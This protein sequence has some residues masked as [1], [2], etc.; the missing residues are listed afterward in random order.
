[1]ISFII[2][3]KNEG[4][5]LTRCIS[6]VFSF[7][8]KE[9]INESEVIYVDSKSTDDSISRAKALNV[10]KILSIT[11]QCNAAI[12]RNI[13]AKE[14]SG[15]ILFFLDGDME[16]IPGF[17]SQIVDKEG[18]LVYPFL[19]GI[20]RDIIHTD[21]GEK[22][23]RIRR[24]YQEGVDQYEYIT[25]GLFIIAADLWRKVGGMDTRLRI[26][27]DF[28]LGLRLSKMGFRLCRKPIIFVNHYTRPY[29]TRKGH[30]LNIRF[31]AFLLRKHFFY[32]QAHKNTFTINY[33][34]VML[35]LSLILLALF[36]SVW[37][38]VPYLIS[39]LYKTYRRH[40][41][42]YSNLN[43]LS[44]FYYQLKLDILFICFFFTFF[45]KH[46]ELQYSL[47]HKNSL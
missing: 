42:S 28:D 2:I 37:A 9:Q 29:E 1:M 14:S 41:T 20:E 7:I 47:Y 36:K 17:Y 31:S 12:A 19:S 22:Q 43:Y 30:D 34:C 33:P 16:L 3:G 24:K 25:G 11:G 8:K 10:N 32:F 45:P 38:L 27:E 23:I 15:N 18:N 4:E 35:V 44:I 46:I 26:N 6:S 13:G 40:L 5:R 39:A 21:N